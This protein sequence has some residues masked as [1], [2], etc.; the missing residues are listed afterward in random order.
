MMN[1]PVYYHLHHQ[2][3]NEDLPFWTRLAEERG[4]PILELGCGTG[5]I[6]VSLLQAGHEIVGLDLSFLALNYLIHQESV[7]EEYNLQVFQADIE[8]FRIAKKFSLLILACNTLSTFQESM[9]QRVYSMIYTHMLDNGVFAASIAN[10]LH[11]ASL[12]EN[13]EPEVEDSFLD[14]ETNNPV[15]VSSEWKRDGRS[16]LISWHYDQLLPNGQVKRETVE[17]EHYLTQL[18]EYQAELN[19]ANLILLNVLGDFDWSDYRDDSPY[20][21]LIAGKRGRF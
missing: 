15:Q 8:Q 1:N 10:P 17:N 16:I 2:D 14:P 7:R 18:E 9:R 12:P 20:L 3:A 5:R 19:R 13:G 6:L 21:I 4:S 11:L